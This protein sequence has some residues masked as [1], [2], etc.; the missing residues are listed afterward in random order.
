MRVEPGGMATSRG[1][2]AKL[3]KL[4]VAATP[5]ASAMVRMV[6]LWSVSKDRLVKLGNK[7]SL[8]CKCNKP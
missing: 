2:K 6:P 3:K 8:P 5:G 1:S 4:G 7:V